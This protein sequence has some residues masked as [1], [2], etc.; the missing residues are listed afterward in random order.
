MPGL[1]ALGRHARQTTMAKIS[2]LLTPAVLNLATRAGY[3]IGA[4]GV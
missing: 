1:Y 2:A 3:A 4:P